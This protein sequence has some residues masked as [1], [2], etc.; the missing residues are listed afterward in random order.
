MNFDL[1]PLEDVERVDVIRGPS[2]LFGRNTL[3]GAINVV[4]R[5]GQE[6]REIVPQ[7]SVGSFGRR[8]YRLRLGGM[9]QPV[10]YALSLTESLED[11]YRDATPSRVSRLFGK[12]GLNVGDTDVSLSYQYSQ[13]RIGQAGSLPE[14]EIDRHRR[15]TL[16]PDFFAPTL[17][18]AILNGEHLIG[19]QVTISA[20]AFVRSLDAE[21]FNRNLIAA[22]SRLLNDTLSAGGAT[23]LRYAGTLRGRRNVLIAG[24]EYARHQCHQPDLLG[25]SGHPRSRG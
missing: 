9:S 16:T 15:R 13:N 8:E 20:N 1:I 12:L 10:D 21:Q 14:S 24:A 3:G 6:I 23:Q 17:H 25:D 11:G 5:R 19:E 22:N 18:L 2:V 7:V 4:T